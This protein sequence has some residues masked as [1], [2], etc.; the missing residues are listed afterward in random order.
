MQ[1]IGV[2]AVSGAAGHLA[3]RVAARLAAL[4]AVL[5]VTRDGQPGLSRVSAAGAVDHGDLRLHPVFAAAVA[6]PAGRAVDRALPHADQGARGDRVH[7]ARDRRVDRD[8]DLQARVRRAAVR[9]GA[10]RAAGA[11]RRQR[12][13]R[14]IAATARWSSRCPAPS[15]GH[16]PKRHHRRRSGGTSPGRDSRASRVRTRPWSCRTSFTTLVPKGSTGCRR[17][18]RPRQ[19]A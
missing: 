12:A 15:A 2:R 19:T 18:C 3:G 4:R 6:G 13:R 16:Q 5:L 1:Q 8:G 17:S 14:G 10:G 9:P 7:H 11:D